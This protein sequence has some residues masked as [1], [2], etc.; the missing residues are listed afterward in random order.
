MEQR[1]HLMLEGTI[2]CAYAVQAEVVYIYIRGEYYDC[3][4]EMQQAI[5]EC[6]AAGLL[7]RRILNSNFSLDIYIHRGA[8]A[9]ICGEETALLESIEGKRGYPRL[10][11]PFPAIEGLYRRPTV[12][13]NVETLACVSLVFQKGVEWFKSIGTEKSTGPKMYSLS[14]HVRKPGNYEAPLGVTL[15]ELIYDFAGG[16]RGGNKF[17][18]ATPGGSSVPM[19][20]EDELD[21]IMDYEGPRKYNTYL[22]STG[23]IVMDETVCLVWAAKNL[24]HFYWD[25]S[26]GQCTPC[27]EGTGWMYQI[28]KRLEGG[29]GKPGEVEML[30]DI[31]RKI[32]GRSICALGEFATGSLVRT[33]PRF[34]M[35]FQM[36]IDEKRCPF[37]MEYSTFT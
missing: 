13:N 17:K 23:I 19:L 2:I 31:C 10:R 25:E 18:A 8:G 24:M 32:T 36:H 16:I 34:R 28:L 1:P 27:R 3:L 14:G 35:E 4:R 22:G 20:F 9:Y 29:E 11:P 5:D 21:V 6:Y 15:R 30:E 12:I 33:I 37:K 7:G 26:C